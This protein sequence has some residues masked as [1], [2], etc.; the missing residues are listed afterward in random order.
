MVGS[1]RLNQARDV[2]LADVR[3]RVLGV[4]H[5]KYAMQ[6]DL[7]FSK[8]TRGMFDGV[9]SIIDRLYWDFV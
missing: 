3:F 9:N 1:Q 8:R 7:Y 4:I 5:E 6:A 2:I